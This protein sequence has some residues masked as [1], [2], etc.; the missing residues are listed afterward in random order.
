MSFY[1][2]SQTTGTFLLFLVFGTFS[3]KHK[4]AAVPPSTPSPV[5]ALPAR[6][7]PPPTIALRADR[8][9]VTRGQSATLT[10]ATQNAHKRQDRSRTGNYS[11]QRHASSNAVI[12]GHICC[13]RD[14]PGRNRRRQCA[15]D[16]E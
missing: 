4:V 7:A 9:T 2:S 5:A 10:V 15:P 3:C 6:A 12:V 1:R 8:P 11:S 13:D 16:G 14:R